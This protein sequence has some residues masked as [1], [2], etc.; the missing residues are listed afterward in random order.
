MNTTAKG[1]TYEDKV[2]QLV[3]R[4]IADGT[5][6]V[7]K[8]Y[9]LHKRK[10][11]SIDFGTDSFIADISI[12]VTNPHF[13]NKISNLIIFECKDLAGKLDKSDFEEWRGRTQNLPYG[14]KL[15][16]VTRNGYSQPVIDKANNTGIGLIV[17]S[18]QGEEKWFAP[19]TLNEVENR[20]LQFELLRGDDNSSF[21]PLVYDNGYFCTLGEMLKHNGIPIGAPTLKASYLP[22][23]KIKS[24]VNDLINT[25]E[26][27]SINKTKIEDKLISFLNVSIDFQ[28]LPNSQNGKYD[29][30]NH[31]IIIPNWMIS[32]PH[33]LRFSLAHEL[34]HAYLHREKLRQYASFFYENGEFPID[35]SD[36][37]FRWFDNQA[38]DFA[39]YL[40][41]PDAEFRH[42]VNITFQKYGLHMQPFVIDNQK[43]KFRIYYSI[44]N[45]L[46]SHFD[47][48]KKHVESRLK[49][50]KF[51]EIIYQPSRIGNIIRGH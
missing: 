19:R 32:E 17:W 39:T 36:S 1:N 10:S 24:I 41:M 22:T 29:A 12:E 2:F 4:L 45:Y 44:V 18:G 8:Q 11:Y 15:Y 5:V 27:Y 40:L 34:G 46:A 3:K 20:N 51:V 50:D 21:F 13:E 48:S 30:I 33:R 31:R 26:F 38:N 14:K 43:G 25:P 9:T 28:E 23:D 16:F 35:P 7:G 6:S 49:K 47:V 42:I 37:E